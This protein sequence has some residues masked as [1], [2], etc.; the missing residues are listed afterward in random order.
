VAVGCGWQAFVAYVNVGCYYLVGL[1]LGSL[2]GFY[3]DY[4]AK[5]RAFAL[6]ISKFIYAFSGDNLIR[7]L[8]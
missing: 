3:F 4:G 5:V 8:L 6:S 7:F 2:L 1:P